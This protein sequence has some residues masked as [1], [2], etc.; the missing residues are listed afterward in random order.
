MTKEERNRITGEL[1]TWDKY[2]FTDA[3][4]IASIVHDVSI[5]L[6]TMYEHEENKKE[7]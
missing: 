7:V 4:L 6:A 1:I 3:K 2:E 5:V